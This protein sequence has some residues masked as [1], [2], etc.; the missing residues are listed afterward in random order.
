MILMDNH[1]HTTYSDGVDSLRDTVKC[2]GV[3]GYTHITITDHVR[4]DS[5]W[6]PEYIDEIVALRKSCGPGLAIAIGVEAKI[7]DLDGNIDFD[8]KYRDQIDCVLASVHRIPVGGLTFLKR[9]EVSSDNAAAAFDCIR[10]SSLKALENPLVDI[11]AHPFSLGSQ[12]HLRT[13][14][15]PAF[16]MELKERAKSTGKYLELNTS[17][18]N[19]C[20]DSAY[21]KS[22]ALKVWLGSDSHSCEAMR[23]SFETIR[24]L[25]GSL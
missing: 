10:Q 11:L 6:L 9:S 17:K 20:V 14:F 18:Y 16:C 12:P 24:C 19:G 22:P 4:K 8:C 25:S 21:W 2:A 5:K 3:L 1:L 15:T 13:Y 7:V 23:Q